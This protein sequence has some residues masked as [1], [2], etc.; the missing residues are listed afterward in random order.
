MTGN[1]QVETA[2]TE[3]PEIVFDES[4]KAEFNDSRQEEVEDSKQSGQKNDEVEEEITEEGTVNSKNPEFF[5][6]L[7]PF[8]AEKCRIEILNLPLGYEN[9]QELLEIFSKYGKVSSIEFKTLK[10]VHGF[11]QF[12]SEG[13]M[14]AALK[15]EDRR[16]MPE[17]FKL[18]KF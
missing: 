2:T 1:D 4:S 8:E 12:Q 3:E 10:C 5:E 13:E 14:L 17:G 18:S 7:N 6:D 9:S 16:E 11:I 15:A